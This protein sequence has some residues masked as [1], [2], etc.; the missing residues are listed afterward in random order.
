[1]REEQTVSVEEE[2]A[3]NQWRVGRRV[4]E[5]GTLADGLKG[6][7]LCGQPLQLSSCEGEQKYYLAHVLLIRC[8]SSDCGVLNEVPTGS[9]H[10]AGNGRTVWDVNTK[11]AVGMVNGGYGET[12]VNTLLAALNI[13][14]VSQKTLKNRE[15]E[16]GQQVGEMAE[17]TCQKRVKG[18]YQPALIVPG[19]NGVLDE[20]I[21]VLPGMHLCLEKRQRKS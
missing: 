9:K 20:P 10:K 5:L 18:V 1:M 21:I 3:R 4:V 19:K 11:L 15:R 13:P 14:C 12:H 17:E 8:K 2:S 7:K 16:V 6:C